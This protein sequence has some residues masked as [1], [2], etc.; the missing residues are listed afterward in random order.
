MEYILTNFRKFKNMRKI[1]Q[2][3]AKIAII[4]RNVLIISGLSHLQYEM[5]KS[6]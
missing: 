5:C 2:K 1:A 6:P 3:Q 4:V